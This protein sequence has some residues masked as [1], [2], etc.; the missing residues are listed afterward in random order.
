[1]KKR[2]TRA[3][4]E[5]TL[6]R[7]K[8]DFKEVL[9][10]YPFSQMCHVDSEEIHF[11]VYAIRA[12]DIKRFGLKKDKVRK[13]D[14]NKRLYV[15]V[16]DEYCQKGPIIYS[17]ENWVGLERIPYENKHFYGSKDLV[18]KDMKFALEMSDSIPGRGY[19]TCTSVSKANK[20]MDNPLLEKVILHKEAE[21][22]VLSV[23]SHTQIIYK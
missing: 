17:M 5:Y 15:I 20:D 6:S 11:E 23:E 8:K 7:I 2:E 10:H 1:M 18:F 16:T 13:E 3:I 12:E 14:F 4:T 19:E 22:E 9:Q 21:P